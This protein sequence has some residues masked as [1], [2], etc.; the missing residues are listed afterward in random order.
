MRWHSW[1]C[2]KVVR[3]QL[4]KVGRGRGVAREQGKKDGRVVRWQG[5]G[6]PVLFKGGG[7]RVRP[8]F[9]PFVSDG[10][11]QNEEA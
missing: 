4:G 3:W 7:C 6:F 9:N 8:R 10:N 2:G 1:R 11:Q 5:G